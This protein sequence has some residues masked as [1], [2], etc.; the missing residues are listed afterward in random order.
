MSGSIVEPHAIIER[1][2]QGKIPKDSFISRAHP[3]T[4]LILILF[5]PGMAFFISQPM[6]LMFLLVS[7]VLIIGLSRK[8]PVGPWFIWLFVAIFGY[9]YYTMSPPIL[10][11]KNLLGISVYPTKAYLLFAPIV[12]VFSVI[13]PVELVQVLPTRLCWLGVSI[14][15]FSRYIK[16]TKNQFVATHEAFRFRGVP[17]HKS[18]F[19]L[20]I[21]TL[22]VNIERHGKKYADNIE[23]RNLDHPE[24]LH[25]KPTTGA[26]DAF[27]WGICG[28]T[29]L[30]LILFN[31]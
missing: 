27:L 21:V 20:F 17:I 15:T 30:V 6:K 25:D 9:L 18:F 29:F 2:F 7:Y 14:L 31:D 19:E 10:S 12:H 11:S 8:N 26:E 1:V 5:F 28:L 3:Y 22:L 24:M 16:V 13:N 4:K 23:I